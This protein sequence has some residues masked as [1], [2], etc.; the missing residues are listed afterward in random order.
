M[1]LNRLA[2]GLVSLPLVTG[3][4]TG[5]VVKEAK[6]DEIEAMLRKNEIQYQN[7]ETKY[8]TLLEDYIEME[9][10]FNGLSNR[11]EMLES[12][13]ENLLDQ[14]KV[15]EENYNRLREE[16]ARLKKAASTPREVT[17][18]RGS[19]GRKLDVVA[20]YYTAL[21]STG[22]TG[23][24]KTGIDVRN[25][26][27]YNGKG[28]VAVDPKVIPLGSTV[29]IGNREYI[30]GDTGGDIKGNRID[31]LVK[32]KQEA[33]NFGRKSMEITVIPRKET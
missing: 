8:D 10:G 7:L 33:R 9:D 15:Y 22:C 3:I 4:M 18:S 17:P 29:I 23:I 5:Y 20:T 32:T 27:T 24:T 6:N 2:V 13:N 26:I 1:R 16:N 12:E 19:S 30:A 14:N 11:M 31:I 28:I 25:S 21:C